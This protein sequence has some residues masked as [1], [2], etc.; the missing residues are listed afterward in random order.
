MECVGMSKATKIHN[1][2]YDEASRICN[3]GYF[4]FYKFQDFPG[5]QYVSTYKP[6]TTYY[7]KL[8]LILHAA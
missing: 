7:S 4:V 2:F 1:L 6:S 8:R 3:V 5:P